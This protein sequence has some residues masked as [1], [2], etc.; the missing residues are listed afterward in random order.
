MLNLSQGHHCMVYSVA[1]S[2]DGHQTTER[3][4]LFSAGFDNKVIGWKVTFWTAAV[5]GCLAS[6]Q[7]TLCT[8]FS[9]LLASSFVFVA[10]ISCTVCG[11][12]LQFHHATLLALLI[13]Y[14][15]NF[16]AVVQRF[17]MCNIGDRLAVIGLI[18]MHFMTLQITELHTSLI[19]SP[20]SSFATIMT[21]ITVCFVCMC[22]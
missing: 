5:V 2:P 18:G 16:V 6:H 17:K 8:A 4:N 21:Y 20:P 3:C 19:P 7:E 9:V 13:C 12:T 1:W 10:L 22:T 14:I 11:L 15:S